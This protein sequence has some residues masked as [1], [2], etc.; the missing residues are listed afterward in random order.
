MKK[1]CLLLSILSLCAVF[2]NI[3]AQI[4]CPTVTITPS[5]STVCVGQC[6]TLTATVN[7]VINATT[8][9]TVS[10][11][12]YNPFPFTGTSVLNN[13]DDEW[14]QALNLGFCFQFFN[15]NY[16][17]LVIGSNGCISFDP[18]L[19]FTY[20]TWPITFPI[21]ENFDADMVGTVMGPWHDMDPSVSGDIYYATYG[22]APCRAFVISWVQ[23]PM[24]LCN[25]LIAQQQIVLY[26]TSNIIDVYITDK[27]LCASWN[28]GAAIEGIQDQTGTT[29][30][31]VAGRNYPTQWTATN[32]GQRWTPNGTSLVSNVTWYQGN[33]QVGTG[34]SLSVC[35][36]STTIYT[37]SVTVTACPTDVT[38]SSDSSTVNVTPGPTLTTSSTSTTCSGCNGTAT[39]VASGGNTPYTYSWNTTP[40]QT[41]PVATGLCAGTYTVTVTSQNGCVATQAVTI[42]SSSGMTMTASQTG[43]ILC[44]G[45]CTGSA[46]A[47]PS[48]G[49]TPYSYS[50][51]TTPVQTTATAT[52]LC[53]GNYTVTVTD[54]NNCSVQQAVTIT[55][56]SALTATTVFVNATCSN[57]C[58]GD[59]TVNANGGTSPY[60]YSWNTTPVQTGT[61]AT[62]LCAGNYTVTVTDANGCTKTA[63][64]SITQPTALGATAT[65]TNATCGQCNGTAS[66][67]PS[68]GT[69]PYT[70][71]WSNGSSTVNVSNLCAGTYTVTLTDVNGCTATA[72]V[73]ITSPPGPTVNLQNQTN[74]LCNGGNTGSATVTAS[75]SSPFT[76]NWTPFGGTNATATGLSAGTYTV[77]V[78][79]VNGCTSTQ[80][81]TITQ[82]SPVTASIN[83]PTNITCNGLCNG[84]ATAAGGGGT[85][86]YTY[87]WN[88]TPVQTG[89]NATGLC[90]GNYTV[91]ITDANG[92]TKTASVSVTQPPV[93]TAASSGV[94]LACNNICNGTA[95]ASPSGGTPPYT[96]SWSNGQSTQNITGL[97]AGTFSVTITDSKGCTTTQSVTLTQPPVL[98]ASTSVTPCTLNLA[99]GSATVTASGGTPNYTYAWSTFPVQNT[100]TAT[101]LGP[102]TYTVIVMDSKGCID[103]LTAF[104]DICP[105]DSIFIPNVFTPN[106]DGKN[107]Q[108][109]IYTEGYKSLHV[110]IYDRWG[111]LIYTWDDVAKGWNGKTKGGSDAPSGTYYYVM[112]GEKSTGEINNQA[113][114]LQLLRGK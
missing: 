78:T 45:Q 48:G 73:S 19:A 37:A 42:N 75:G 21:P 14:S 51:N 20:N 10:S 63:S 103:T 62:G 81:V 12:P 29:A 87:S 15:T 32:D 83:P 89:T 96:Y 109:F 59:A 41:T 17:Q 71:A 84:S 16:T 47:S 49:A 74:V 34:A 23:C 7:P 106:G 100:Q 28:G 58:N 22:N 5:T 33:T 8:G 35:P 114:F 102:G 82:P 57:L 50:W 76:Y 61:N 53:A 86:P 46:T 112:T 65:S 94:N 60:T 56:P 67:T 1:T 18:S 64:V 52:G 90:A 44:N 66:I 104:L 9:Y 92:C 26:E 70:Y 79:D 108:F 3:P 111:L 97:C 72:T 91:T 107:D 101:A 88:T 80:T 98:T 11:I 13:I 27:P 54:A 43:P 31:P 6:A 4:L 110:D 2:T 99:N 25:N 68:G 38:F 36:T 69:L 93:L 105:L 30:Y 113:G 77:T 39:V 40:V 85:S 55:Q 24:F 95:N